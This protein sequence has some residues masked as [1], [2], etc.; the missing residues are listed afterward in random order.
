MEST[1]QIF[2]LVQADTSESS[3]VK[4]ESMAGRYEDRV[5]IDSFDFGMKTKLQA[6]PKSAQK[7]TNNLDF[8]AVRITKNFD[9]ASMN[10][11]TLLEKRTLLHKVQ[12]TV[13]QHLVVDYGEQASWKARNSIIVIHLGDARIVD[14]KL[15]VSE[16][17]VS[18]T[19]KETVSFS[20]R[21][22]AVEYFH[23]GKNEVERDYRDSVLD[24]RT[25]Y[26]VQG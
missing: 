15:D 26:D 14:V 19:I 21:N 7:V 18:A 9:R 10:L 6:P 22:F 17:K 12:I 8:D 25:Q 5:Q 2:L 13:D 20:F 24:F 1:T 23:K 3:I 16:D 11:A 4:G